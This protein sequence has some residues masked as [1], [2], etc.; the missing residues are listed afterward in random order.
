MTPNRDNYEN[1]QGLP[2]IQWDVAPQ[3]M[4]KDD[5]SN[6]SGSCKKISRRKFFKY[7][8][9]A[10]VGLA[11]FAGVDAFCIEPH[12]FKVTEHTVCIPK[13]PSAWDGVRIAHITD[14]H[15]G[16][17]TSYDQIRD[18]V[19]ISNAQNP[20][21]VVLTGDYITKSK[22]PLGPLVEAFRSLQAKL[23][24]FAVLGNHDYNNSTQAIIN[25]AKSAGIEMMRNE[26]RFI[27]KQGSPICIA[28]VEDL[29]TKRIDASKSLKGVRKNI[30][31][32]LL[33]HNPDYA[34]MLPD[35]VNID[36]MI[37]GHTHG[38]Q[39][40][41]PFCDAPVLPIRHKKY[42]EGLVKG[43]RCPVFISRGLGMVGIKVRFNCRPEL[44]IIT[45]KSI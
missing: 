45:L 15:L 41:I 5:Y 6:D 25:H 20:D 18:I 13:L 16:Q 11:T 8:A 12:W 37:C 36:L 40:K 21:I 44:P 14:I 27:T 34:E 30:P 42:A 31:T 9:L 35:D 17:Y 23:G 2:D 4:P 19:D 22:T 29:W 24:K 26:H 33:C 7:S 39:V 43:P 3:H 28:G 32:I 38:G 10:G 1:N